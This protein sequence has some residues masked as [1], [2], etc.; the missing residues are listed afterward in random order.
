[1]TPETFSRVL[2]HLRDQ[3][4]VD[5]RRREIVVRDPGRLRSAPL[6]L[7][8]GSRASG[9]SMPVEQP[10]FSEIDALH[11]LE[12]AESGEVPHWFS[13]DLGDGS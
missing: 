4:L 6:V 5:V 10:T 1:M 13:A 3:G 12:D 8:G 9:A 11:W 2:H 7:F